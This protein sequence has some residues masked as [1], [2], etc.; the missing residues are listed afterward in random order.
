MGRSRHGGMTVAVEDFSLAY[1]GPAVED[2]RMPIRDLAPA[3]IALGDLF[4]SANEIVD[5]H[6]P[7][8]HLDVR[9][10]KDGS[11]EAWLSAVSDSV[12]GV[13][14]SDPITALSTLV[15]L[16]TD[17][18]KGVFAVLKRIKGKIIRVERNNE[19]GTTFTT[20][21][22]NSYHF[23]NLENSVVQI[24]ENNYAREAAKAVVKPVRDKDGLD[25]LT[26][27]RADQPSLVVTKDDAKEL[28]EWQVEKPEA[29][30]INEQTFE[31]VLVPVQPTLDPKYMARFLMAGTKDQMIRARVEDEEW[32]GR[33][34]RREQGFFEGDSMRVDLRLRQW[35]LESNKPAEY[36][37][38]KVHSH[39]HPEGRA[40]PLPL[41]P[42]D[43][44]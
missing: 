20:H 27:K 26:I 19:G 23:E 1:Q 25:R 8:V 15:T 36:T 22:G 44:E 10:F 21:N 38:M 31:A 9:T 4:E 30:V 41:P 5:P 33:V 12:E 43:E 39:A 29:E 13:L 11:V 6:A 35:P 16:I 3:L 37:V 34:H 24:I 28:A 32:W 2:G 7:T 18:V 42:G 17:P 14:L 40:V